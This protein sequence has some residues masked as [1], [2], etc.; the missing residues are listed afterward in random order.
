MWLFWLTTA[1]RM[2]KSGVLW[3]GLFLIMLAF[4]AWIWGQFVQRSY[5]RRGIAIIAALLVLVVGYT[6]ILEGK[7]AWRSSEMAKESHYLENRGAMR[8]LE[9]ARRD[10][11]PV[12]VDFTADTCLANCQFN[13]MDVVSRSRR[14]ERN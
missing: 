8:P 4:A 5:K 9:Q 13:K 2:G 6:Y 3:F 7:L 12:L 14:S 1:T 10:G 11:H